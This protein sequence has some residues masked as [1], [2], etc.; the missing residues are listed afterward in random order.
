MGIGCD[1]DMKRLR[2]QQSFTGKLINRSLTSVQI[3]S[4]P[5]WEDL[6]YRVHT[7]DSDR[8]TRWWPTNRLPNCLEEGAGVSANDTPA[9][10]KPEGETAIPSSRFLP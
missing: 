3:C 6:G 2:Y 5:I 9:A 8:K 1:C 10:T 7:R 4:W